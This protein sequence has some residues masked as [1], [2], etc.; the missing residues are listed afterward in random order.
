MIR[1]RLLTQTLLVAVLSVGASAVFTACSDDNSGNVVNDAAY[2]DADSTITTDQLTELYTGKTLLIGNDRT[3]L[4]GAVASRIM[5][6]TTVASTDMNAVVFT[7]GSDVKISVAEAKQ[8]LLAYTN[9][10]SVVVLDPESFGK[11]SVIDSLQKAIDQLDGSDKDIDDRN[12]LVGNLIN[13][14]PSEPD[15]KIL[16]TVAYQKYLS[17]VANDESEDSSNR[18]GESSEIDENGDTI[19]TNFDLDKFTPNA[20][21]YGQ[22]ADNLV[23][24]MKESDAL[25]DGSNAEMD[26]NG[27]KVI[28]VMGSVGPTAAFGRKTYYTLKYEIIPINSS[29]YNEDNYLVHLTAKFDNS[30]LKCPTSDWYAVDHS[31]AIGNGKTIDKSYT[32]TGIRNSGTTYHNYWTGPY[33]RGTYFKMS[34]ESSGESGEEITIIDPK[35]I[36]CM[37]TSVKPQVG[38]NFSSDHVNF[39]TP[40]ISLDGYGPSYSYQ[41][42]KTLSD[43]EAYIIQY[44][45]VA[46]DGPAVDWTYG[47]N[48]MDISGSGIKD[49]QR[50]D[51]TTD[52]TWVVKVKNTK[53]GHRYTMR[54]D[55][56][57]VLE[58]LCT[59]SGGTYVSTIGDNSYTFELPEPLRSRKPYL[60]SFVGTGDVATDNANNQWLWSNDDAIKEKVGVS[61]KFDFQSY[62]YTQA[63]GQEAAIATFKKYVTALH[64]IAVKYGSTRDITLSLICNDQEGK[65]VA[66]C[67]LNGTEL[68]FLNE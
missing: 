55:V 12:R 11:S 23:I 61:L 31:V 17:Y 67:H 22:S 58:E 50:S 24:W 9:N 6:P 38:L 49:F 65:S 51:W 1:S 37:N 7:K 8:I 34:V 29:F 33:L 2:H 30:K 19:K 46:K 52:L 3:D 48:S 28:T 63:E 42:N 16:G 59:Y 21:N 36:S 10:A 32:S 68:T 5:N 40:Q 66:K 44:G 53:M 25:D 62:A 35:P 4:N 39:F 57:P 47:G 41:T 20:Y 60:I 43:N 26:E 13:M 64:E 27:M 54:A 56:R 15:K 14:R 18:T 45:D